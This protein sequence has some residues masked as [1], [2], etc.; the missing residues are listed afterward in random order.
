MGAAREP[1]VWILA[2]LCSPLLT[3]A[4]WSR[5]WLGWW[6]IGPVALVLV[7]NWANPRL[8]APPRDYGAWA[9]RAV[10]GER[11]WLDRRNRDLPAHHRAWANGLTL[12]SAFGALVWLG[13]IIAQDPGWTCAG[14]A[15]TVG[16]KVW[17]CDRMVWLH[18]DATG[19]SPGTPLPE[20]SLGPPARLRMDAA[21][22]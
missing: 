6:A 21:G 5:V 7:W 20:P 15:L 19:T 10:L 16:P 18:A 22:P 8:F 17:F 9:S 3:L 1:M 13:G 2:L 4:I 14:L 11:V 12:A